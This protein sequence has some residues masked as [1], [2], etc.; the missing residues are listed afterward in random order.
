MNTS[1]C[2]LPGAGGGQAPAV[3]EVRK[4]CLTSSSKTW[5]LTV[6]LPLICY[7]ILR[8]VP[9]HLWTR[10]YNCQ[11]K[12]GLEDSKVINVSRATGC[13]YSHL[14]PQKPFSFKGTACLVWASEPLTMSALVFR[15]TWMSFTCSRAHSSWQL[16]Q[17]KGAGAVNALP[18]LCDVLALILAVV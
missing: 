2:C 7:E 5:I 16:P 11:L 3:L 13:C 17:C 8:N 10:L 4:P 6:G 18:G 12:F 14:L 9:P 15:L 1:L